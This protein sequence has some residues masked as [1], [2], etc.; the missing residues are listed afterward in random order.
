MKRNTDFDINIIE[1]EWE[2][3][4]S[5]NILESK[6]EIPLYSKSQIN[7]AG[8]I[9]SSPGSSIPDE[10]EALNILNNWRSAHAYPLQVIASNL[11]RNNKNAI[12]VQRLITLLIS[13]NSSQ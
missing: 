2:T 13:P 11:R 8:K 5:K 4:M 7:K 10:Q 9:I 6:W 3:R 12:V 1:K